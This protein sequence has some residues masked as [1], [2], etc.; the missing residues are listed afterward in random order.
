MLL[1]F[2]LYY[3]AVLRPFVHTFSH[4]TLPKLLRSSLSL[5]E[6]GWEFV[7]C[8]PHSKWQSCLSDSEDS[9]LSLGRLSL[10]E[11]LSQAPANV[12]SMEGCWLETQLPGPTPPPPEFP[13]LE[14][15]KVKESAFLS[16]VGE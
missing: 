2:L 4:E 16:S 5:T 7:Q 12:G 9:A 15:Y 8:H 13:V 14:A 3:F 10:E 1:L 6:G 11:P